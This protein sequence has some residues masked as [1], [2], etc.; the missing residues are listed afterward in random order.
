METL[1]NNKRFIKISIIFMVLLSLFTLAKFINEV[2]MG[3]R[4]E[5]GATPNVITVNGTGEVMAVSDIAT[6]NLTVSKDGAI[7]Q[8]S[9]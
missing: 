9:R 5:K 6:I 8:L 3:D 1:L 7:P 2:K 4:G